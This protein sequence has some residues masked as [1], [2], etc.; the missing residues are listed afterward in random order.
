MR[1]QLIN[2]KIYQKMKKVLCFVSNESDFNERSILHFSLKFRFHEN[3]LQT[4]LKSN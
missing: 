2:L 4:N 3:S 1:K